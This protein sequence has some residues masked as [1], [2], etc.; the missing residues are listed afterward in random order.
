MNMGFRSGGRRRAL[1][2]ALAVAA[3]SVALAACTNNSLTGQKWLLAATTASTPAFQGVVPPEW[4]QKYTIEFAEDGTW[5]G[6]ADCN[7]IAGTYT[8]SG[9]EISI[10]LGP[11]TLAACPEE[12]LADLYVA[13]LSAAK[14]YK[15]AAEQLV[16]GLEGDDTFTFASQPEE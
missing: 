6:L 10:T 1:A 16:L 8:T 11:S 15:V 2:V 13:G 7:A 5:S 12:S 9:D 3:L 14:T 4:M